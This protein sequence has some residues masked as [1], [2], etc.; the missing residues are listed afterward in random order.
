MPFPQELS[1]VCETE[2]LVLLMCKSLI[3][4][5]FNIT[6]SDGGLFQLLILVHLWAWETSHAPYAITIRVMQDNILVS[7]ES[8][9]MLQLLWCL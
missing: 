5:F 8:V 1:Y 3:L 7:Y 4:E 2:N 9:L 6:E